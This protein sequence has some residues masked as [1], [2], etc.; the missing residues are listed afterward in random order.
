MAATG[1]RRGKSGLHGATVPG[2]ARPGKPEG[3]R[4]REETAPV[5]AEVRV[6]RWGK[7]PPR[8]WRQER[9]GKPHREQC[10][11]GAS[12]GGRSRITVRDTARRDAS[13]REARVGSLI[14]PVT[15]GREEWSSSPGSR[16]GADRIRLTGP[17]RRF[18]GPGGQAPPLAPWPGPAPACFFSPEARLSGARTGSGVM[19]G[20]AVKEYPR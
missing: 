10:Q 13:A 3:K 8:T 16:S 18:P 4:H 14:P 11:I 1:N 7:S 19:M 12:R 5:S 9:H 15:A 20:W 2:N 17:P 6:K